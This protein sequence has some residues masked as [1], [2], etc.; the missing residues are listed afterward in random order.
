MTPSFEDQ[1]ETCLREWSAFVDRLHDAA[2]TSESAARYQMLDLVGALR[3]RIASAL[4]RVHRM[5]IT[6][7]AQRMTLRRQTREAIA[8]LHRIAVD[9]RAE[10]RWRLDAASS[11]TL[12][13][14]VDSIAVL[15]PTCNGFHGCC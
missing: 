3:I 14:L 8:E 9:K 5:R 15:V 4:A 6:R 12:T 7:G 13:E 1:S 2:R 10:C 11:R